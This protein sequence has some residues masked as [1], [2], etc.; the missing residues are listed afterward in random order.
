[1]MR[2]KEF[3]KEVGMMSKLKK[4]C[5]FG[6]GLLI[7][8]VSISIVVNVYNEKSYWQNL[9]AE[10]NRFHWSEIYFMTT[11]IEKAG[12]TKEGIQELHLYINAKVFSTENN[13]SPSFSG[14]SKVTFFLQTY[15]V[16]LAQDISASQEMDDEKLQLAIDL[17]EESTKELKKLSAAILEMA[18]DADNRLALIDEDSE[19]YKQADEMVKEYSNEYSE[20]ISNFYSIEDEE[21][22]DIDNDSVQILDNVDVQSIQTFYA[23]I[24]RI[25]DT[26]G[27][28]LLVKGM[29]VNDINFRGEFQISVKDET[30]IIWRGTDI[31]FEDLDVGDNISI[32]FTGGVKESWPGKISEVISIQLLDD[33]L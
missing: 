24:S 11:E 27:N 31:A 12:F 2:E 8:I 10:H 19:L 22:D 23:T 14:G 15:Y 9:V 32:T 4:S 30:K 6:I 28:A 18:Q 29:E 7:I 16:S 25:Y 33:D 20:R 17:F 5:L 21:L 1:M 3:G 26:N 13:L